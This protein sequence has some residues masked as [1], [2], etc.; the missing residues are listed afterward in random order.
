MVR[1]WEIWNTNIRKSNHNRILQ[2]LAFHAQKIIPTTSV[3]SLNPRPC[4][5]NSHTSVLP[6]KMT[7]IEPGDGEIATRVS[8]IHLETFGILKTYQV[9][10]L[11]LA[12]IFFMIRMKII[13]RR[14]ERNQ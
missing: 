7:A 1:N 12:I 3:Q 9:C 5:D 14:V 11:A 4:V 2:Q 13:C 6:F 8:K 10:V